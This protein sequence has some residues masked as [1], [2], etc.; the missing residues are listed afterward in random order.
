MTLLPNNPMSPR[1]GPP[2]DGRQSERALEIRRGVTRLL[3]RHGIVAIPEL[4]LPSGRRADLIGLGEK[5]RLWIIEIKSC[6]A[7]FQA[8][9]KWPDYKEFSDRFF[10]AVAPDFPL[11]LLPEEAGV[12]V[13]DRFDAEIVAEAPDHPLPSARRKALTLRLARAAAE[14]LSLLED[15]DLSSRADAFR[16]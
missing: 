1:S 7:D 3:R 9:S 13:A 16:S 11:D 8:D 5:G 14:R 4:S 15:P 2:E 12:I 6:R 10:F